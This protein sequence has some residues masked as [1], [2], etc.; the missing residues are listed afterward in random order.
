MDERADLSCFRRR[1]ARNMKYVDIVFMGDLPAHEVAGACA[2]LKDASV[3]L[4]Y[5]PSYSPE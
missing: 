5:L 4:R 1:P 3:Q 2:I